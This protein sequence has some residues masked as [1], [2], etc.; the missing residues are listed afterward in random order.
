MST[1][2][3]S[4]DDRGFREQVRPFLDACPL[5]ELHGRD[6]YRRACLE[7]LRAARKAGL[8][9]GGALDPAALARKAGALAHF[10][11]PDGLLAAEAEA[12][13]EVAD[14]LRRAE[15]IDQKIAFHSFVKRLPCLLQKKIEHHQ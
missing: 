5:A 8:L 9:A 7:Q 3:T 15:H 12:L 6:A 4:G 13:G 2:S 1:L 14:D 10:G 11:D